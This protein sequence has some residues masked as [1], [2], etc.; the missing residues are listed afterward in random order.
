[1]FSIL[2]VFVLSLSRISAAGLELPAFPG[3]EGC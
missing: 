3:A 1:M 2:S